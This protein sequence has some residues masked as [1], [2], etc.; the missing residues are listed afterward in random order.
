MAIA[1]LFA[2]LLRLALPQGMML[3]PA[4]GGIVMTLCSGD[5]SMSGRVVVIDSMAKPSP[6]KADQPCA[7]A[8]LG[9]PALADVALPWVRP[10]IVAIVAAVPTI[11]AM[12]A[13]DR[14]L[15]APPPP[16][17]GPPVAV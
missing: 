9:T 14:G 6:A 13:I 12:V 7:F 8:A 11:I 5:A 1:A 17:T 2:L 4:A 15:A 10:P 3:A 16:P